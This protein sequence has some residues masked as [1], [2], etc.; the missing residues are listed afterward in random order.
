MD[1]GAILSFVLVVLS[2][3]VTVFAAVRE[4]RSAHLREK[5]R[6]AEALYASKRANH[7]EEDGNPPSAIADSTTF[8]I[9]AEAT[10]QIIVS[11]TVVIIGIAL[12]I[13]SRLPVV[14]YYPPSRTTAFNDAL[15]LASLDAPN[16]LAADG[17]GLVVLTIQCQKEPST[18]AQLTVA[19]AFEGENVQVATI[20]GG[21]TPSIEPLPNLRATSAPT[22]PQA[23]MANVYRY[24]LEAY[25]ADKVSANRASSVLVGFKISNGMKQFIAPT[26]VIPIRPPFGLDALKTNIST[27]VSVIV[28]L[29]GVAGL[30]KNALHGVFPNAAGT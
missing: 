27:I 6:L 21:V 15:C 1:S 25:P 29:F 17:V 4:Q 5:S 16:S 23:L 30:I 26:A 13:A 7:A 12:Y 2:L 20:D 14:S 22:P 24:A 10:L 9:T 11:A 28:A 3:G 8:H 19:P 18:A